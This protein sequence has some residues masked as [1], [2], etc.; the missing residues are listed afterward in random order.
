MM[1]NRAETISDGLKEVI[2]KISLFQRQFCSSQG[3]SYQ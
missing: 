2:K 1:E 3:Y